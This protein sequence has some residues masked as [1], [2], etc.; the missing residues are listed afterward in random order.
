MVNEIDSRKPLSQEVERRSIAPNN[1]NAIAGLEA[2][3]TGLE[4]IR[5]AIGP[6]STVL[7]CGA[8]FGTVTDTV[9]DGMSGT[10]VVGDAPKT[11]FQPKIALVNGS[12]PATVTEML[13]P[14]WTGIIVASIASVG[15]ALWVFG[16]PVQVFMVILLASLVVYGL[17]VYGEPEAV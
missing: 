16:F 14:R 17:V 8:L 4:L 10:G 11:P 5:A 9:N 7:A 2:Y 12:N 15:N 1:R 13:W 6:T 3:R